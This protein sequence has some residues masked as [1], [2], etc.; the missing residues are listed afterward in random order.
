MQ[1]IEEL[2]RRN[3]FRVA[4]IYLVSAWLLIQIVETTFPAFGFGVVAIRVAV[5]VAGIGFIP[6]LILTWVFEITPEGLKKDKDV[7]RSQPFSLRKDLY[8]DRAIVVVL[9]LALS[10]LA[11]DKFVVSEVRESSIAESA[12][13]E[14]A[15]AALVEANAK[16]SIAVLPFV[17]MSPEGDQEYFSDGISEELL[18]LLAKIPQLR[19]ISRTSAFSYKGKD[20]KLSEMARELNVA[21]IL[22]GSLRKAGDQ[23]RITAQ[24]IEAQSDVHLWSETYDRTLDDIFAIQDEIAV[25]VVEQ[26]KIK[27]L[28]PAPKVEQNDLVAYG[29]YLRARHVQRGANVESFERAIALYQRALEVDPEYAAPWRGLASVYLNQ[30]AF[31]L[32]PSDDGVQLAREA[33]DK[34]LSID[35]TYALAHDLLGFMAMVFEGDLVDAAR[36]IEHALELSPADSDILVDAAH[37]LRSLGRMEEGTEILEY[38]VARDPVSPRIQFNLAHFY[39]A[40]GRLDEAIKAYRTVL[41]LSPDSTSSHYLIGIALLLENDPVSALVEIEKEPSIW[42][43]IGLPMVFHAL[44][45]KEKSDVALADLI[46]NFEQDAALNIAHVLAF[47][48][49]ADR[50]FEWLDKAVAYNDT[51]LAD[52]VTTAEFNNLH[53]DPRWRPFLESIGKSPQQ[54]AAIEFRVNLPE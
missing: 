1:I 48:G 34:A 10:Y 49:E 13:Q 46:E 43:V 17:D 12:L 37:L 9:V 31:G 47:R 35:P 27:L 36:H 23:I 5:I 53:D 32:R 24:L 3:V 4:V 28:D 21:H 33:V 40:S 38:L 19:V 2:R 54:L 6:T 26:L 7:D 20:I 15:P 44:Q 16:A 50:A 11:I 25:E 29:F 22:E 30:T 42:R 51:G 14:G 39:L 8:L 45:Q 41:R 52:I 18:N